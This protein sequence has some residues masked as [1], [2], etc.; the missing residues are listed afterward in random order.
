M[1]SRRRPLHPANQVSHGAARRTP[2]A[3]MPNGYLRQR[4]EPGAAR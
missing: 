4:G 3:G 2:H 1:D